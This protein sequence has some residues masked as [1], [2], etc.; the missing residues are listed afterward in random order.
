MAKIQCKSC[1]KVF[2]SMLD[3][4]NHRCPKERIPAKWNNSIGGG[5]HSAQRYWEQ[6]QNSPDKYPPWIKSETKKHL[7]AIRKKKQST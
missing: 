5:N 4:D 7:E 1:N 6:L 3:M 2:K